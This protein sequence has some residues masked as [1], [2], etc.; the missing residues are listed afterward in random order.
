MWKSVFE[1]IFRIEPATN[2]IWVDIFLPT[3]ISQLLYKP[4]FQIVGNLYEKNAI[5]GRGWGSLIHWLL[6]LGS[7][8]IIIFLL[9]FV[10][11]NWKVVIFSTLIL[12]ILITLVWVGNASKKHL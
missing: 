12:I 7:G 1:I 11:A 5:S 6:R 4:V 10:I 9:N 8:Y 3:V 2:I